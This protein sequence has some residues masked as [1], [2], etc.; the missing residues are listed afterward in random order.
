MCWTRL[1]G[2]TGRKKSPKIRHVGTIVQLCRAISWQ[3]RHMSTI[4][5]KLVKQQYLLHMLSQY[6]E[7]GAQQ[8]RFHWRVW[9]T[10]ANF[11][12]FR[13]WASLL[14]GRRST[15]VN[16]T[17]H[18]VW[19]SPGLVHYMYILGAI[20][21]AAFCSVQNSPCVQVLRSPTLAALL[22]GTWEV[23][24]RQTAAFS[25]G[26][27]L[28]SVG[29][30]SRWASANILVFTARRNARIA[31]A[32]LATAIPSVCPSVCH[33]LVLCQNDGT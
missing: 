29:R 33:T 5:K 28:Y 1:A 12:G 15:E 11:N 4:W 3:L 18:D 6:R 7:F 16:Q 10:P 24:V 8:L 19:T 13:V 27:H 17:L 25:R 31:S 9:G 22:H 21:I 23:G 32:V 14:H 2:N 20:A 26:R 30:P